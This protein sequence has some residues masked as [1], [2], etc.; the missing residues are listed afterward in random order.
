MAEPVLSRLRRICLDL[1]ETTERPS[2][3]SPTF[4][5]R[6]KKTFVMFLDNHH[7]D[8]RVAI[9]CAAAPGAQADQVETDAERFFVPPYVAI[10]AGSVSVSTSMSTGTRSPPSSRT[11]TG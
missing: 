10:G 6:D 4:F 2:H 7:G 11:P 3:G 1:P 5:I 8:G 9:W